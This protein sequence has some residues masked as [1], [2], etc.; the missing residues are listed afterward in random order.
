[1]PYTTCNIYPAM[2]DTETTAT[3]ATKAAKE[4]STTTKTTKKKKKHIFKKKIPQ[5]GDPGYLSPTQLR[6]LRKRK[7]KKKAKLQAQP[8]QQQEESSKVPKDSNNS[9][10]SNEDVELKD[11]SMK[12][13]TYPTKTPIVR[14]AKKYIEPLLQSFSNSNTNAFHVYIGPLY[15]WRTVS[16][17]AVRPDSNNTNKVAIGLFAENS[18]SL[19]P[20]PKCKAHHPSINKVVEVVTKAC[21][22]LNVTPYESNTADNESKSEAEMGQLRYI[23][24]NID[25]QSGGAQL[26]LVWNGTSGEEDE[27][28]EKLVAAILRKTVLCKSGEVGGEEPPMKRQ[29]RRGR[30]GDNN[31]SQGK[32][33]V[34]KSNASNNESN[35]KVSLHSL[36]INYNSS[37]KHSNRIFEYDASCW[38][39]VTGPTSITEHLRFPTPKSEGQK[40]VAD[41]TPLSYPVPLHFP[42][43]VFRQANLDSFTN[44]VGRIRERVMKMDE[45]PFSVELYGGVGTI[46]LNLSDAVSHIVSSDENPNN[47]KCFQDS[48][49][50]LPAEIQPLL[51]YKQKN[52][53]D[54]VT[55]EP[56]LFQKCEL[57]VLDPPRKGLEDE[58]VDF[59]CKGECS[60]IKLL[61]Y[62]SC[63]FQ[64]FQR[65]CDALLASG[66]WGLEFAEGH[67]LFPGSDAIETLAFFISK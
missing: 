47:L 7:A 6:N 29:R 37:W 21:H 24:V 3:A 18:H 48:V 25:R 23:G 46:A 16:K 8:Q 32:D 9:N 64:A 10:K 62:V 43:T 28:L 20:V 35:S 60:S 30:R 15:H 52:A 40:G 66:R 65:D 45:K 39:H 36:W 27:Q 13:I 49:K 58:V 50:Q 54:M 59:L 53:A 31:E 56:D 22:E 19:L 26:T 67:V 42:P 1:M 41:P 63:G 34:K 51:E 33:D 14:T 4:A 11:P 44:I 2:K 17:L 55:S 12:Y 57:L 5:K 38:R 61:V